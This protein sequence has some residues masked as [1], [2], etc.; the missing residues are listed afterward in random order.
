MD[1]FGQG[2]FQFQFARFGQGQQFPNPVES[3]AHLIN[4][5][6]KCTSA[7][8]NDSHDLDNPDSE[9]NNPSTDN[10]EAVA[11]CMAR[12]YEAVADC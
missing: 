12:F 7:L 5:S 1:R 9:Y 4:A 11:D 3:I 8:L 10:I 2:R 6:D